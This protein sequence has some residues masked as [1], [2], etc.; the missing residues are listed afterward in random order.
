[1]P[2][3]A[4]TVTFV[5]L[6]SD[7]PFSGAVIETV[8]LATVTLIPA[9]VVLLPAASRATAV[10]VWAAL[11]AVVVFQERVYGA[12]VVSAPRL[13][14]SSLNWT[15]TTPTV[16][17]AFADTVIVPETVAPADGAVME[18]IGGGETGSR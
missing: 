6:V 9:E 1:M 4:F 2:L 17:V 10:R 14:P 11:V 5:R 16:S 8:A 3:A 7:A 13:A 12:G 15:P 18:T